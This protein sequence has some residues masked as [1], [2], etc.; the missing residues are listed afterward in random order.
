L[1]SAPRRYRPGNE[2]VNRLMFSG[3]GGPSRQIGDPDLAVP[4]G[5]RA[6]R[7][8]IPPSATRTD[9]VT[10]DDSSDARNTATSAISRGMPGRPIGTTTSALGRPPSLAPATIG[11]S[12]HPGAIAL[13][14]IPRV[15]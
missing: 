10:N 12:T 5:P 13:H 2:V 4:R 8:V 9:P 15:A 1:R 6:Q 14:R 3:T 7:I 11:V